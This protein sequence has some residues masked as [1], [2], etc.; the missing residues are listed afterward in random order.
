MN[1]AHTLPMQMRLLNKVAYRPIFFFCRRPFCFHSYLSLFLSSA[2]SSFWNAQLSNNRV[3]AHARDTLDFLRPI[4]SLKVL[5][6]S[7]NQ[8]MGE[9]PV[10]VR[11]VCAVDF[12][13]I[14]S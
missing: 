10:R 8:V 7:Y 6:L 13:R 9:I 14:C 1:S 2:A 4:T 11:I 3:Y 5:D 12:F